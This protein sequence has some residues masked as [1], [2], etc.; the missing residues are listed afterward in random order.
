MIFPSRCR[1]TASGEI[2]TSSRYRSS[3]SRSA[4]LG[5]FTLGDIQGRERDPAVEIARVQGGR[6]QQDIDDGFILFSSIVSRLIRSRSAALAVFL[7]ADTVEFLLRGIQHPCR[8]SDQFG[9]GVPGHLAEPVVD[10]QEH[11]PGHNTD[12]HRGGLEDAP[13]PPLALPDPLLI[14]SSGPRYPQGGLKRLLLPSLNTVGAIRQKKVPSTD[15]RVSSPRHSS[16][17]SPCRIRSISSG[18]TSSKTME[19]AVNSIFFPNRSFADTSI[20]ERSGSL[21]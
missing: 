1:N 19:N 5:P 6:T 2:S 11:A 10:F 9:G 21:A 18:S 13:Q 15:R 20:K 17:F 4:C 7:Q 8:L 3:L 16:P 12:T 14:P